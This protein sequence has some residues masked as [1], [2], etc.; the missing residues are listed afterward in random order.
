MVEIAANIRYCST[1]KGFFPKE[2]FKIIKDNQL[3]NQGIHLKKFSFIGKSKTYN[4]TQSNLQT[5]CVNHCSKVALDE[6][7]RSLLKFIFLGMGFSDRS[8][9]QITDLSF[10]T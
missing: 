2:N 1:E 8:D 5:T 7:V 10:D 9:Q 6:L 4:Y 3:F